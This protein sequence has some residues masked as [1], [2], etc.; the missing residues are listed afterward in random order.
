[1]KTEN[2]EIMQAY[3]NA[4]GTTLKMFR[5]E[6]NL[7]QKQLTGKSKL[8]ESDICDIEHGR[9]NIEFETFV[10]LVIENN[11]ELIT[12]VERF[13]QILLKELAKIN[14]KED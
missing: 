3:K 8:H 13:N 11:I 1:M 7:L 14:N 5:A 9:H 4:F 6:H 12:F 10:N 2:P